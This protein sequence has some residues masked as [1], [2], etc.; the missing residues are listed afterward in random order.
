MLII[1]YKQGLGKRKQLK[2]AKVQS[3]CYIKAKNFLE[4]R[5]I[6]LTANDFDQLG[7]WEDLTPEENIKVYGMDFGTD[8]IMLTDDLGKTP[9]DEKAF[10]VVAAYDDSDCFLWGVELKGFAAFKELCAKHG[11]G[12]AELLEALRTY[13]LPK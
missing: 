1:R 7:C 9:T 8:Y 12:S 11:A 13:K 5:C 3:T 4:A 2:L 6:M 10:L